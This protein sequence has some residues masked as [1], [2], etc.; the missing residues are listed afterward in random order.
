[1]RLIHWMILLAVSV[2]GCRPEPV[3]LDPT[4][5]TPSVPP[6]SGSEP[7]SSAEP[8]ERAVRSPKTPGATSQPW[9]GWMGP[10]HDG[11]STEAGWSANWPAGGLTRIWVREIGIGF[12]S[13]SVAND[14]LFTMG[15]VEGLEHVYC[16]DITTGNTLWSHSYPCKLI[17]H[18]Y[19]GGPNSTPTIDGELLFTLGKEGQLYCLETATGAVVWEHDLPV[20]LDVPVPEWG[21]GSS[22]YVLGDQLILE[23]GRVVSYNKLTGDKI[24]QTEPHAAGY[25][26]A[27]AFVHS[28]RTLLATLDND[29]L[30]ITNAEDG[31]PVAFY[32]W[33]SPFRTNSTTPIVDGDRLFVSTGY[34]VGCGLFRLDN[35]DQ[36]SLIYQNREMRNHFNNSILWNGFLYGFDGNSNLGRVVQLTCLNFETGEVAWKQ[37]GLGCGSLM[38]ADGKLLILSDDGQLVLAEG[39]PDEFR[40]VTRSPL[41]QGRCWTVPVLLDGRVYARNATGTLVCVQLP[42]EG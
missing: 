11:I 33:P 38:V 29:G 13:I 10:R 18:L 36:L 15:H 17:A 6:A 5:V 37:R 28:G 25:G 21:F 22:A 8:S 14:R 20:D 34:N 12:S 31:S 3:S 39:T 41:L 19:E 9:T 24:W 4:A 1:M 30:R 26:S 27:A 2:C 32:D 35:S 16:V 7:T 40:E 23:A 42:S